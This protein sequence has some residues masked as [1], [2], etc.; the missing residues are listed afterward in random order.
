MSIA[1][2]RTRVAIDANAGAYR[3]LAQTAAPGECW[4]FLILTAANE[5]QAEGYRQE[6]A[7]R[8]RAV[9]AAGAFFP[10]IQRTLVVPDP[11]GRRAGSGGAT[12]GVLRALREQFGVGEKELAE[13]RILLIHSG[14][15]SQRLPAYSALGKIFAPL[16]LTRPDGQISTL[17]DHLYLTLC[18]LPERLG[19]GMLVVAGDVFLVLDHRQ[20]DRPGEGVTALTMP[21][22]PELGTG[23]GVFVADASGQIVRTLQKI[24]IDAMRSAGAIDAQGRI[25]IDTGLLFFDPGA[26]RRLSRLMTTLRSYPNQIDLY[27]D[28]TAALAAGTSRP[29]YVSTGETRLRAA[30][31][32]AFHGVPFRVMRL[33]GE[34]LHL[35]TTLQFRDAMVGHNPAPAAELFQQNVLL[36][37]DVPIPADVRVYHSLLLGRGGADI[38]VRRS[39]ASSRRRSLSDHCLIEHSILDADSRIG[40]GS[41][42]SQVNAPL[43]PLRLGAKRL[44]FSVPVRSDKQ[45]CFVHVL[46]GVED[47]FK[48]KHTDGNCRFLNQPI[49]DFLARHKLKPADLW[50]GIAPDQR[51]LWTARL[52]PCT[53]SPAPDA[54]V[55]ALD[56]P[57]RASF[58]RADRYSMAMLLESADPAAMIAHRESVAAL[59]RAHALLRCIENDEDRPAESFL[60]HFASP[61]AHAASATAL[62]RYAT[63]AGASP[64]HLLRQSRACWCAAVLLQR[65]DSP[66]RN[67]VEELQ[68]RSFA[69]IARAAE[70][71]DTTHQSAPKIAPGLRIEATSPVRLDLAGG[72]SDT[73]PYCFERG[74]HVVN[75]AIDLDRAPPVRAVIRTVREPVLILETNDLA[76]HLEIRSS[77]QLADIDARRDPFAL[78][79]V[80]LSICGIVPA[81]DLRR[82]LQKLGGGLIVS[83]ECRVP[84]GSGLGTSSI[85][86]ATLLAALEHLRGRK[87]SA[88]QLIQRTLL[89]E[90]RLGT[91][92][93]WQD[94]VG[95]I[96]G[97]V[98]S[99]TT[100]PGIPQLP[101]IERLALSDDQLAALEQRLVV[102]F[103]GQQRLARDILRRVMGRWLSREVAVVALM[104]RLQS[105]ATGIRTAILK[106]AW[107]RAAQFAAD[108]WEIKKLLYPGSTTPAVDLLFLEAQP[109]C[110]SAGLAGAGGGGFAYFLCRDAKQARRLRD[111]L[112]RHAALPGSLGAVFDARINRRGL[113]VS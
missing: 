5:K 3:R 95:G 103:S 68:S 39:V 63:A 50:P 108:Y 88:D 83:T 74:G 107:P 73:P 36:H 10:P 51:T 49:D 13:L 79:K 32:R 17:F 52:F 55:F 40:A 80:A 99:T 69:L 38:P 45:L 77:S 19:P 42:V 62:E 90:Q 25:L 72:W 60:G 93:G 109:H 16:P 64:V 102:Y 81:G 67:R 48:G 84:K 43:K 11:P 100:A 15:A 57:R 85:L 47:D 29:Q 9:G 92:G 89:L 37:S 65:S 98:K 113:L 28:M 21:V 53:A 2:D 12:L 54:A 27:E 24:S 31:W 70:R 30:L 14:G 106:G 6:L 96:I 58:G 33:D 59:L 82:G 23:H 104:Q 4:D 34:F 66:A 86:A 111:V 41:V 35:G 112:E 71:L 76:Q 61:E 18:G 94:Q 78:H 8:Q 87:P 1:L 46:C 20:V 26:M 105:G 101:H 22:E 97:G 91:G 110:L 7:L 44:L 56:A 75:I